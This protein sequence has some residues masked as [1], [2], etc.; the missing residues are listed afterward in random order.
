[1][2]LREEQFFGIAR[3]IVAN[4]TAESWETIP[5]SVCSYEADVTDILPLV[6]ELNEG[7]SKEEKLSI[8]TVV[9]KILCEGLKAAPIM[10]SHLEFNRKLVRGHLK[11]YD[12]I[13]ISMP[14][15]LPS[16]EMMTVNLRNMEDKT[17][18]EMGATIAD[19]AAKAKNTNLDEAFFSV[20]MKDTI[21]GLKKGKILQALRRVYGAKMPGKHKVKTLSGSAKKEYYKIP[22]DK[23]LSQKDLEQGTIT[24][25]NLG[26]V[27][28]EG[29]GR[30]YLLEIIPPQ[31]T[32]IAILSIRKEP[33]VVTDENGNDKIEIRQILPLTFAFDHRAYDYGNMVPMFKRLDE[34]FANPEIIKDWK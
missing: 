20:S 29:N 25:S 28:R 8:N 21:E 6:K 5:H 16:G 18:T 7:A 24:I 1:M 23:R 31:T 14:M 15:I 32:V 10:N 11:V 30:C 33:I 3:K 13:N 26:S 9:L 17:L 34:I 4:M 2:K 19:T 22:E 27:Y 12:N